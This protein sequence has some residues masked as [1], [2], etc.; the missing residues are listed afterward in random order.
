MLVVMVVMASLRE[1]VTDDGICFVLNFLDCGVNGFG[2]QLGLV[3][4]L[5]G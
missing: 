2:R 3:F 4:C 5:A 1:V